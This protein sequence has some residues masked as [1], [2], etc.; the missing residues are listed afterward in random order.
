MGKI[1]LA[2]YGFQ[3]LFHKSR[4]WQIQNGTPLNVLKE[5]AVGRI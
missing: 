2:L 4:K 1:I 3:G 5:L